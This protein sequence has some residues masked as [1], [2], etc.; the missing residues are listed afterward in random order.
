MKRP[1]PVRRFARKAM[2]VASFAA[3]IPAVRWC[4]MNWDDLAP[5][6][7][8]RCAAA[9]T[10]GAPQCRMSEGGGGTVAASAV[11]ADGAIACD[12]TANASTCSRATA[13]AARAQ[14][15]QSKKAASAVTATAVRAPCPMAA[16][17]RPARVAAA[18][19]PARTD[20]PATPHRDVPRGRAYLLGDVAYERAVRFV[21]PFVAPPSPAPRPAA[22]TLDPPKFERAAP[23]PAD[24]RPL[25]RTH[26]QPALARAPPFDLDRLSIT[27]E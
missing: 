2:L 7:F 14:C 9:A 1:S 26:R 27:P 17:A 21:R 8:I 5:G 20:L 22:L 19:K 12:Q 13:S 10:I 3:A 6:M 11:G 25:T 18:A 24:E 23:P 15:P 4:P 16:P